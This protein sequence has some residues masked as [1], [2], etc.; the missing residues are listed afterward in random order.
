MA[1]VTKE[2]LLTRVNAL[3]GDDASDTTLSLIEDIS[4]TFDSFGEDWRVKYEENDLEWRKRYKD[5]FEKPL[6]SSEQSKEKE[7][8]E[9]KISFDDLFKAGE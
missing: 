6:D 7:E 9:E 4:D 3:A 1:I 5:R 8:D 2:D